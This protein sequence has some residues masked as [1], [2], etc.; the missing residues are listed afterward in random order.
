M[1]RQVRFEMERPIASNDAF[2][3]KNELLR[4]S[5]LLRT[6]M[7]P[8]AFMLLY[9]HAEHARDLRA[10]GERIGLN[11]TS[12]LRKKTLDA[13]RAHCSL[14]QEMRVKIA[15]ATKFLSRSVTIRDECF[16]QV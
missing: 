1:A 14:N 15:E 9:K 7:L 3:G 16:R 11:S 4:V 10:I 5:A 8:K 2:L 12:S 13:L 6:C